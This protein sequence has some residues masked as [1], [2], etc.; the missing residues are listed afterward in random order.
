[1]TYKQYAIVRDQSERIKKLRAELASIQ[2]ALNYNADD[3]VWVIYH[4][5]EPSLKTH[6]STPAIAFNE[7]MEIGRQPNETSV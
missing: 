2:Y 6:G 3:E 5:S 1:M 7:L 4:T